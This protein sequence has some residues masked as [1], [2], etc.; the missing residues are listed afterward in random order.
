MSFDYV[1]VSEKDDSNLLKISKI[2][3]L[4]NRSNFAIFVALHFSDKS[5]EPF[6]VFRSAPKGD[7]NMK[8][9]QTASI[10]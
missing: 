6:T 9:L 10:A 8:F 5:T 2:F 4:I 7:I 3:V 1:T